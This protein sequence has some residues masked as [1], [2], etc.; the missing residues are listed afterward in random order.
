[1]TATRALWSLLAAVLTAQPAVSPPK[2]YTV[3]DIEAGVG[4]IADL[5]FSTDGRVLVAAGSTGYGAWDAQTG[6][7]IRTGASPSGEL[8]RVALAGSGIQLAVGSTDGRVTIV[9]LRTGQTREVS[10]HTRPVTALAL[11]RD[12]RVGAS[13]DTEGNVL[14]WDPDTGPLG[15]LRDGGH[16]R[17]LLLLAFDAEGHLTSASVDLRL[18]TWDVSGR[19]PLRRATVES[20]IAGRAVAPSAAAIDQEA[21]R[22]VMAAQTVTEPRGGMFTDRTGP[23]RPADLRRENHLMSYVTASGMS[24][25]PIRTGDFLARHVALSPAGCFAFFTSMERDQPRLHVWGLVQ[26]GDDLLRLDLP[27]PAVAVA[28]EPAGRLAAV[29]MDTGRIRTWRVSGAGHADCESYRG[30]ASP[31]PVPDKPSV[32]TGS[33]TDPLI[34]GAQGLRIA[35]LRF[36]VTAVDPTLGDAVAEMVGGSLANTKGVTVVER[37]QIDAIVRE[38]EIQRSGLTTADAVRIGQGLNVRK[39]LMGSV[40]R[41]GGSAFVLT[42]RTVDVE[43]QQVEG[44]REVQCQRCQEQDLPLAVDALR[45]ILVR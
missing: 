19:R 36:D 43:T 21:T 25:D 5:G 8:T 22:L 34:V 14:L 18:V 3:H 10:R 41:L 38:L 6:D 9:D 11:A 26:T 44:F 2:L 29:A 30:S 15:A 17:D 20:E 23:A 13:G 42:A 37:A 12:G 7:P 1:M 32:I 45:R 33:E 39:V 31:A 16:K 27:G 28:L 40:R 24:S 4:R 35:V